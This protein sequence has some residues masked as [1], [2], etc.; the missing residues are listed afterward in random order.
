MAKRQWEYD[1]VEKPFS[2]QLQAKG[3]EWLE[4]DPASAKRRSRAKI[5]RWWHMLRVSSGERR[6]LRALCLH[7]LG[8]SEFHGR[9]PTV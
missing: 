7:P 2:L 3:W 8:G 1:L 4:G 6:F 9:I 5:S